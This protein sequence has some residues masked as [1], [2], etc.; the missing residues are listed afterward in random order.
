MRSEENKELSE[1]PED[2]RLKQS[3]RSIKEMAAYTSKTKAELLEVIKNKEQ[4]IATLESDIQALEKCKRYEDIT[5]EVTDVYKKFRDKEFTREE[6]MD[7]VVSLINIGQ[8]P[9]RV[10][11][12]VSYQRYN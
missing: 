7:L 8:I 3:E 1:E 4:E 11:V 9:A 10:P 2:K 12:R 6:S 5:D